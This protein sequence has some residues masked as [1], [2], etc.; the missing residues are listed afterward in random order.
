MKS[1][2]RNDRQM[3]NDEAIRIL[4]KGEFGILSTVSSENMPYGVP[5]SYVYD[6]SAIYLHCALEGS[7]LDNIIYNSNV[8][9][10]VVGKTNVLPDKFSTE[11]ESVIV[12]GQATLLEGEEKIN[13]LKAL[14]KKYSPG[15][16]TEGDA[17]IKQGISRTNIIKLSITM[18]TGKHR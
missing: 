9:F 7:K 13:P 11:Y 4:E 15:F 6:S 1:M 10:T 17:Y 14:V 8:C 16:E 18:L 2:R 3:S 12:F 5:I